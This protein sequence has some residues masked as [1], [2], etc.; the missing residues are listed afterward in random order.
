MFGSHVFHHI[1]FKLES[2]FT[3]VTLEKGHTQHIIRLLND[4]LLD[5]HVLNKISLEIESVL[6]MVTLECV[7]S[8]SL[9]LHLYLFP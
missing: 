3:M 6:T 9:H 2:V 8:S 4:V 5:S 7:Y 1:T